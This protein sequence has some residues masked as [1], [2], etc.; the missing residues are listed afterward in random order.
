MKSSPAGRTVGRRHVVAV[1]AIVGVAVLAL[2][3]AFAPA[4]DPPNGQA[5]EQP[6]LR[7]T[8]STVVPT[9]EPAPSRPLPSATPSQLAAA[10]EG[11]T[12]VAQD[13]TTG[14]WIAGFGSRAVRRLD[15]GEGSAWADRAMVTFIREETGKLSAGTVDATGRVAEW[16]L[17]L[18]AGVAVARSD[19][20]GDRLF[21]HGSSDGTDFGVHVIDTATGAMTTIIAGG[22]SASGFERALLEWSPSAQTLMSTTCDPRRCLV[23]LIDP[24]TLSARQLDRPFPA[25]S[26]TDRFILGRVQQGGPW[27]ALESATG[28]EQ[29]LVLEPGADTRSVVPL[30]AT[31]VLL[32]QVRPTGY[33]I[34]VMDLESG[35]T[36]VLYDDANESAP[37]LRLLRASVVGDR[38]IRLA[39]KSSISD[40]LAE[41]G[42]YPVLRLLDVQSGS[43]EPI[44]FPLTD[45]AI[46]DPA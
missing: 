44:A 15:L 20:S 8:S 28:V 33:V 5:S 11:S 26:I 36:D 12:W 9:S 13:P 30:D 17:G 1:V 3:L 32:D 46:T 40:S 14:E 2:A 43:V 29:R 16:P 22:P 24:G 37:G 18:S 39:P 31:R 45:P 19:V 10:F 25:L 35:L 42:R 41:D 6:T 4:S 7:P 34:L 21:V 23:D 27:L 38:W